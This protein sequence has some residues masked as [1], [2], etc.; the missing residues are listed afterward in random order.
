MYTCIITWH[1]QSDMSYNMEEEI[2]VQDEIYVSFLT[3]VFGVGGH[4]RHRHSHRNCSLT[5]VSGGER[6]YQAAVLNGSQLVLPIKY[7]AHFPNIER[8]TKREGSRLYLY[9]IC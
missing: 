7:Y 4:F 1:A 8:P 5:N 2:N 9:V 3:V 6:I